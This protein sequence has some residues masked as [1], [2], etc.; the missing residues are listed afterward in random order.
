MYWRRFAISDIP[1]ATPEEF[2]IWVRDRWYEKDALMEE[3]MVTGRFPSTGTSGD[4]VQEG[5]FIE[6]EVKPAH[7]WE[8]TRIFMVLAMFGL[9]ANICAKVYNMAFYGNTKGW[10]Y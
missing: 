9:V 3:Y 4:K 8:F 10:V 2:D 1:L 6:T 5:D 7:W